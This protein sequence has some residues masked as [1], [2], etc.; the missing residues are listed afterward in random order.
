MKSLGQ[1]FSP[2]ALVLSVLYMLAGTLVLPE[3]WS[4]LVGPMLK[5]WPIIVLNVTAL[6]VLPER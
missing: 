6:A 5:I 4:D 1:M 3:L 2:R